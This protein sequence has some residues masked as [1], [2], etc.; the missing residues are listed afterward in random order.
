ML[1]WHIL[2]LLLYKKSLLLGQTKIH[3]IHSLA[4]INTTK[5]SNNAS[6]HIG[7]TTT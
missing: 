5:P 4:F 3:W 7:F 1:L 6:V 2:L